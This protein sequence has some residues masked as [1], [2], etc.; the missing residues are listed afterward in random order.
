MLESS[1]ELI[2]PQGKC[3]NTARREPKGWLRARTPAGWFLGPMAISGLP[4]GICSREVSEEV[5][6]GS[7]LQPEKSSVTI[8]REFSGRMGPLRWELTAV[9]GFHTA[10]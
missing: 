4:G 7:I 6:A 9:F 1:T 5:S 10:T 8:S 2:R 3:N